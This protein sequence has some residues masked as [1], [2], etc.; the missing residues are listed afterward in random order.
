[1]QIV[2]YISELLF[3]HDCVILPGLGGFIGNY[4][5]AQVHPVSHTFHPPSK[6]I[7]FNTNL[8]QDDGLLLNSITISEKISY[9]EAKIR[10][11]EFVGDCKFKLGNSETV[12]FEKVGRIKKEPNGSLIFY[13]DSSV[14]YLRESF[15]MTSFVSPVIIRKPVHKGLGNEPHW[16]V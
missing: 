2:N 3:H 4:K 6:S 16:L 8:I 12:I 15:G 14:N 1:M 7:L 11:E 13:P 5:P 10:V 9:K